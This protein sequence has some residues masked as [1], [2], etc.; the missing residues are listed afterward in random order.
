MAFGT[1]GITAFFCPKIVLIKVEV[2]R[3]LTVFAHTP[4]V[5]KCCQTLLN[6]KL[7]Y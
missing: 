4:I 5:V 6:V 7:K 3:Y 2:F 1:P